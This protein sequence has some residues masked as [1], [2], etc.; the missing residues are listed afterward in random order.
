M[1]P[2]MMQTFSHGML[3]QGIGL[4]LLYAFVI[5]IASLMIYFSTREF[6]ELSKH[7]GIRYFREAFL[8]F[9][10]AF[11]FHSFVKIVVVFIGI[12][13][14]IHFL[15]RVLLGPGTMFLYL[16]FSTLAIGYLLYSFRWKTLEKQK[17][18]LP[19]VHALATGIGLI[20]IITLNSKVILAINAIFL[21]IIFGII[22]VA[23][24][25][26]KEKKTLNLLTIYILLF[27]FWILNT[28]DLFV[29]KFL[30]TIQLFLY[31]ASVTIFLSILYKVLRKL[32][33]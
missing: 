6:Y 12:P 9:A 33:T 26:K 25:E 8:F 4:E 23:Y 2:P 29:P 24:L 3:S 15:L 30:Q 1:A 27:L 19:L 31:L 10:I 20:S 5:I 21:A 22:V 18:A 16:Y 14:Q 17:V 32:G 13:Q 11:F 28:L 7:K